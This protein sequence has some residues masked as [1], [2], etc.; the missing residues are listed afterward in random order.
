M[1][2]VEAPN[3]LAA[4][5]PNEQGNK[6]SLQPLDS[7][8]A[9]KSAG[10]VFFPSLLSLQWV[11]KLAPVDASAPMSFHHLGEFVV[12]GWRTRSHVG[13]LATVV[14]PLNTRSEQIATV[15]PEH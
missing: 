2:I 6:F 8:T 11:S 7:Y 14:P 1:P 3:R 15:V 13:D 9:S 5:F 10:Q 12:I 4:F